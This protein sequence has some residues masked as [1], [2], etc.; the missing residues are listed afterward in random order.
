MSMLVCDCLASILHLSPPWL[1][2]IVF[3][4]Q[5]IVLFNG[6]WEPSKYLKAIWKV[7]WVEERMATFVTVHNGSA[8]IYSFVKFIF[9][10]GSKK[11]E[12]VL[13]F[14]WRLSIRC[15]HWPPIF[16]FFLC[17]SYMYSES[18]FIK[19]TKSKINV[20][21]LLYFSRKLLLL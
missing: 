20:N 11:K 19:L 7:L 13:L 3:C 18:H 9:A 10:S 15:F 17:F 21:G 14:L 16:H 6:W 8:K 5:Q 1:L 4:Q 2:L 12:R